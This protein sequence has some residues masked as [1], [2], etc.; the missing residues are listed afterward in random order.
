[1]VRIRFGESRSGQRSTDS[2]SLKSIFDS[3][4]SPT[5][6]KRLRVSASGVY[7]AESDGELLHRICSELRVIALARSHLSDCWGLFVRF[8]DPDGYI[9]ELVMPME[10]FA[11]DGRDVIARLLQ[12][13]LQIEPVR[14]ASNLIVQYLQQERPTA[15]VRSVDSV[16]WHGDHYVLPDEVF[17]PEGDE[18]I[19]LHLAESVPSNF[20][21]AGTFEEW[22]EHLGS[23]CRG[24]SRLVFAAAVAFAGPLL[25]L[26]GESGGGF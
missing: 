5:T 3:Q 12:H 2:Q 13:G 15:R 22:R 6:P 11:G 18:T 23:L 26:L 21:P 25:P 19:Q 9:H 7:V 16:G 20:Q 14:K 24:N 17:G 8:P 4:P 10:S 1:M